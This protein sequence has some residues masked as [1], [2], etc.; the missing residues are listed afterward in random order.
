LTDQNYKE[1]VTLYNQYKNKNFEILAFPCNQFGAQEPGSNKEIKDFVKKYG[2]TFQMMDKVDVNGDGAEPLYAWMKEAKKE[3][4]IAAA[5]GNDIKWNF[6]K[7]LVDG[8][9]KVVERYVPTT[10]PLAIEPDI[11]PLLA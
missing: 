1:L 5:M 8:E 2:V 3:G 6:G 9:G 11:K 10:S 7:F 4:G